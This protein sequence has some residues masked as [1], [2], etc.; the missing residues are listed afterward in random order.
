MLFRP[1]KFDPK[2]P[3]ILVVEAGETLRDAMER[4]RMRTGYGGGFFIYFN[5]EPKPSKSTRVPKLAFA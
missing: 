5:R 2:R 3:E 4:Q 1:T